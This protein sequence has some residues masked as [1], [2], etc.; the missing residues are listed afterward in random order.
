MLARNEHRRVFRHAEMRPES[1]KD[2]DTRF[3][4][5]PNA[6]HNEVGGKRGGNKDAIRLTES[7]ALRYKKERGLPFKT[8]RILRAK[9]HNRR[10]ARLQK[11]PTKPSWFE[12]MQRL[13]S[14]HQR[15]FS[16][17][18]PEI[19]PREPDDETLKE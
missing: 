3:Q 17:D 11:T 4:V 6:K 5:V 13:G 12:W 16:E 19:Q 7:E 14:E 9:A 1:E 8:K 18:Q 2:T 10:L 15:S